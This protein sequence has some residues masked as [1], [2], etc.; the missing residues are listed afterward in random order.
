MS[1][2]RTKQFDSL[3]LDVAHAA[4][5][6]QDPGWGILRTERLQMAKA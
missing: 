2:V 4:P 5:V 3:D 1:K 6:R